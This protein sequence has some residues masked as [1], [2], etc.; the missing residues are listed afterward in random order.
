M[1]KSKYHQDFNHHDITIKNNIKTIISFFFVSHF[2]CSFIS[3]L[4]GFFASSFAAFIHSLLSKLSIEKKEKE[5]IKEKT[6][7]YM[8]LL[9]LLL[10]CDH[11]RSTRS[12]IVQKKQTYG[13]TFLFLICFVC[14][15]IC[16][17]VVYLFFAT[18]LVHTCARV[19]V[20]LKEKV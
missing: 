16:L 7:I 1:K 12:I 18:D 4:G 13:C 8:L 19:Y 5:K 14:V 9:W 6:F 2:F 20:A 15:H 10:L 17:F 11:P 3:F